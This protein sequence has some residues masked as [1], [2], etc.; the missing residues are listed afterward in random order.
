VVADS[1]GAHVLG[2]RPDEHIEHASRDQSELADEYDSR[3]IRRQ[4]VL[5]WMQPRSVTG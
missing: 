1:I 3:L 2:C 5:G 4:R